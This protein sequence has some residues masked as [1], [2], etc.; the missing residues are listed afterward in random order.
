MC[1][2]AG[3]AWKNVEFKKPKAFKEAASLIQHRGPD[4]TGYYSDNQ[5]NFVHHRLSIIDLDPRAHQPFFTENQKK[6][7]IY[8][9]EIYNYL[10]LRDKYGIK[11]K[12]SSDTEVLIKLYD[13]LGIDCLE[14]LNGIF[15][16]ACYDIEKKK[17]LIARDRMGVKPLYYFE[18]EDY[19]IFASEAKVILKFL[20]QIK[21][22]FQ[23]LSE[24]LWYGS[25]V[26]NQ[27][28]AKGVKKL[29]PGTALELSIESF[30]KQ[31]HRYWSIKDNILPLN[32]N[33]SLEQAVKTTRTLIEEGVKRQCLSDVPVGAYL[34]GGLDSSTVVAFASKYV[35]GGKL[36]TYSAEFDFNSGGKSELPEAAK[37]ARKFNTNHHEFKVET[38]H[39]ED[40]IEE[41]IFQYDEPFADPA[42]LPLHLMAKACREHTKV[43]LQ[44]DGGDELFAG[45]GRHL[46]LSELKFRQLASRALSVLAPQSAM[47]QRMR[48]RSYILNQ[49]NE[50]WR[51]ALL[52]SG[53]PDQNI[54]ELFLNA[55]KNKI[56]ETEPFRVY[57]LKNEQFKRLLPMQRMLYTDMEVILP[58]TYLEKVDK[59]N[60]YHS[61]EARVP[62]LDNEL[63]E[64]VMSLPQHY[65]IRNK[66]TK[67]LLRACMQGILPD[68][69]LYGRK[70]SFGTPMGDWIRTTLYKYVRSKFEIAASKYTFLNTEY[71]IGILEDHKNQRKNNQSAVLWRVTVLIT[72]L[73]LYEDKLDLQGY[74]LDTS[75]YPN[76]TLDIM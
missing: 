72:W 70:K 34:S 69:I 28:L 21:L 39:L 35:T 71:L 76:D 31:L 30:E 18:N 57:E 13:R 51:M 22:D 65:K 19:F 44:G 67:Y 38:K 5:I 48:P 4:H 46:D 29:E 68:D 45:Y 55:W 33:N 26:S 58:H 10:E 43:I 23:A 54:G 60:M 49:G 66:Q 20:P 40:D 47:R 32:N 15:A 37:V 6:A 52:V 62:L 9:G 63:V 42:A 17:L 7:L 2:I 11:Q 8:N 61:I 12:T 24:F 16:F 53:K 25:S 50:A 64:Y 74:S 41:L 3:I 59:I 27:T 14:E 36:N 1:G 56:K 75:C 73:N